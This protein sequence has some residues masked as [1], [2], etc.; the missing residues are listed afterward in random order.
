LCKHIS[1]QGNAFMTPQEHIN[2]NKTE[3]TP[4]TPEKKKL[5]LKELQKYIAGAALALVVFSGVFYEKISTS[6]DND[7]KPNPSVATAPANQGEKKLSIPNEAKSFVSEFGGRYAD[8][9]STY[10]AEKAYEKN[11]TS[12]LPKIDNVYWQKEYDSFAEK[13]KGASLIMTD[14]YI[15]NYR[16]PRQQ[17]TVSAHGFVRYELLLDMPLDR[18]TFIKVFNEYT[19]PMLDNYMNLIAKNPTSAGETIIDTEFKDYCSSTGTFDYD[20][21][22]IDKLMGTAKDVVAKYGSAAN[23]SVAPAS[24][25]LW[26]ENSDATIFLNGGSP[27]RIISLNWRN[28]QNIKEASDNG[29]QLVICIDKYNNKTV[30]RAREIIDDVQ[31]SIWEQP[32]TGPLNES[33]SATVSIGQD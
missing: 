12:A 6:S 14:D 5:S 24:V 21:D 3:A 13:N 27:P 33:I 10:Y 11:P 17:N 32:I 20:D 26:S 2:S 19:K 23:Y 4:P 31:L 1:I 16:K 29:I 9:V 15:N 22:G 18:E 7:T 30:S 25:G 8:P 28:E